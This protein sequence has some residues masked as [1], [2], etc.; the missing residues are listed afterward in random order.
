MKTGL[1]WLSAATVGLILAPLAMAEDPPQVKDLFPYE[2]LACGDDENLRE[3][4]F[5]YAEPTNPLL[6]VSVDL[7]CA[8]ADVTIDDHLNTDC[9]SHSYSLLSYKVGSAL[10]FKV[11]AT[12]SSLSSNTAANSVG[13]AS[14][15]WDA[16]VSASLH[17]GT[18]AGGS[19]KAA[20]TLDGV[21]Q[22]GWKRLGGR[23]VA[24][25]TTWYYTAT[26]LVAESDGEYNTMVAWSTTGAGNAFDL[27]G[28]AAQEQGH[29]F[30]MGHSATGTANA[31]LTMYPYA[32]AGDTSKRTLGDGDILGIRAKYP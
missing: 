3:I 22:V 18:S 27:E 32:S 24:Q 15:S 17:G 6:T 9:P 1:L 4:H 28:V 10:S 5:E 20:G 12:G 31:C 21:N 11:D 19:G 30:G 26:K 29:G 25:Q 14:S 13:S 8:G 23:T 16:K 7:L 2:A